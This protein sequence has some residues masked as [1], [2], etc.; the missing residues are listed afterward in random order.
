MLEDSA[1]RRPYILLT[2]GELKDKYHEMKDS[3]PKSKWN[4][5]DLITEILRQVGASVPIR[6]SNEV[7]DLNSLKQELMNI[8]IRSMA[9]K[10]LECGAKDHCQKGHEMEGVYSQQ[11]MSD[12]NFRG[13][14]WSKF[15][16]WD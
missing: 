9:L 1:D 4:A 5:G 2:M 11:M 3:A 6:W 14:R 13:E 16:K 12:K 7:K 15:R 10:P 8:I